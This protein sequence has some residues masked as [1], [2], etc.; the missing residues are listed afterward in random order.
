MA[1]V[2]EAVAE[3]VEPVAV[4]VVLLVVLAVPVGLKYSLVVVLVLLIL[5][6]YLILQSGYLLFFYYGECIEESWYKK[7][8]YS[9]QVKLL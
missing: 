8:I 6:R 7:I 9:N 5:E 2:A 4:P 1:T 3:F